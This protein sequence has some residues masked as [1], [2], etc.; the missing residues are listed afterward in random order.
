MLAG[1][2][3]FPGRDDLW[4]ADGVVIRRHDNAAAHTI[5]WIHRV[6]DQLEFDAPKPVARFEGKS[7][8]VRDGA[9][10]SAVSYLDGTIVGWD[11][12]PTMFEIGAYLARFHDAIERV[13]MPDQQRPAWPVDE[14]PGLEAELQVIDHDKRSRHVIHGDFTNHNVLAIDGRPC[15]VIDF[16]NAYIDVPLADIGF[17]LWRSGRPFQESEGFDAERIAAYVDGYNSV[18]Q[19]SAE[20]RA[21]VLVYLRARGVQIITKQRARGVHDDGP[22]RR[23]DWLRRNAGALR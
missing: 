6:L 23:L 10:W 11:E 7:V 1:A 4:L 17:A 9:V 16:A 22:V 19:L 20:D 8:T 2:T 15:G 13:A 18:I 12:Q 21:A 5:A 3:Q 14:L